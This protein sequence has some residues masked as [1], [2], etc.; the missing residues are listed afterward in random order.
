MSFYVPGG[1]QMQ[2]T[3][4]R[5]FIILTDF[6]NSF[7]NTRNSRLNILFIRYPVTSRRYLAPCKF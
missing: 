4:F 3:I 5:Y 1:P 6:R 2:G 7:T